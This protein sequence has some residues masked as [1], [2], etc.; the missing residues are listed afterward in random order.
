MAVTVSTWGKGRPTLRCQGAR[1]TKRLATRSLGRLPRGAVLGGQGLRLH[2]V[3]GTVCGPLL[4]ILANRT[5]HLLVETTEH[6]PSDY[7]PST[8][9]QSVLGL[10]GT[11]E[12]LSCT[13]VCERRFTSLI[14]GPGPCAQGPTT[15][16]A[17]LFSLGLG[18]C[19][20]HSGPGGL[21][22]R[23]GQ[24]PGYQLA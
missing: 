21:L 19:M 7:S 1:R 17:F 22:S 24:F 20:G 5:D 14:L 12:T 2:F 4:R 23:E 16:A 10:G 8:F 11:V 13:P 18:T 15:Q 9:H 3:W 6:F